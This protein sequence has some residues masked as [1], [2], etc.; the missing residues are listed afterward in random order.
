VTQVVRHKQKWVSPAL[1]A[2]LD[3]VKEEFAT[4]RARLPK[5]RNIL[6]NS[7]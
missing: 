4:G 6:R 1:Q 7:G 3:V 2:F 5:D